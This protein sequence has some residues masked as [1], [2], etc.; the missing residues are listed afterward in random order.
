MKTN[1]VIWLCIF[2]LTVSCQTHKDISIYKEC[3]KYNIIIEKDLLKPYSTISYT[4]KNASDNIVWLWFER[5]KNLS[6]ERYIKDYFFQM[7]GDLNLF[8]LLTDA[9]ITFSNDYNPTLFYTFLKIIEPQDSFTI[10][11]TFSGENSELTKER[12]FNSLD[13]H[14]IIASNEKLQEHLGLRNF[15]LLN[16]EVFY[17]KN[18][19]ILP[20]FFVDLLVNSR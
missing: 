6:E 8:H 16:Q 5:N 12:I 9:N 19:I 1:I 2:S 3:L 17:N 7:K 4:I 10:Q 15:K 13:K 18:Q 14:I 20:T 11:L